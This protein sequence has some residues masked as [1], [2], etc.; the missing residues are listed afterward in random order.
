[1]T[2]A[3]ALAAVIGVAAGGAVAAALAPAALRRA[4]AGLLRTN[5][6]GGEVPAVLGWPLGAGALV[7]LAA[8]WALVPL[9]RIGAAAV[10]LLA[11][12]GGAGAYDDLRGPEAARGFA[13]HLRA[14]SRGRLT[15]GGVKVLVG[16]LAA[17][18]AGL[19]VAGGWAALEVALL[20]ALCANLVNLLDRAPG[21]AGKV[22]LAGALPLVWWGPPGWALAAAGA[23]GALAVLLP[24]DL[25]AKGMLGDAGSNPLGGLLGL[26]L[27]LALSEPGRLVALAV[28]GGLNL[29]SERWSFSA[30]I[31]A[32]RLLAAL[33]HL[34]RGRK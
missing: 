3:E 2:A 12:L 25:G 15:G 29:A 10:L 34:G 8:A 33:D 22:V 32:N 4:P 21:R 20:C 7:G 16:G 9:G 17:L 18:A 24:V 27:G 1:V 19:A 5:V 26:G 28:V 31:A 14:L 30:A 13:G 6:D 23:L 11:G